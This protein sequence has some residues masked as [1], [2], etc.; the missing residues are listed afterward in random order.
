MKDET[1]QVHMCAIRIRARKFRSRT[2]IATRDG[3]VVMRVRNFELSQKE[4]RVFT[5]YTRVRDRSQL[6]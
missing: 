3:H 2:E 5:T 6:E 4:T 1:H